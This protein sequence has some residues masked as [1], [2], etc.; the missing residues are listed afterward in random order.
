MNL[1]CKTACNNIL[2]LIFIFISQGLRAFQ[3]G[4]ISHTNIRLK[5]FTIHNGLPGETVRCIFQDKE[6]FIWM[7]I[8][9]NGLCRFNGVQFDIFG[10]TTGDSVSLSSDYIEVIEEDNYGNLWIGTDFG[11][12]KLNKSLI[13]ISQGKKFERFFNDENNP[14]SLSGNAVYDILKDSEGT[15][16]IGTNG[17][18][19][20]LN[21]AGNGFQNFCFKIK[22]FD[23]NKV[24]VNAIYEDKNKY[25]WI[26]T[27]NGLFLIS[28]ERKLVNHWDKSSS[29]LNNDY[30]NTVCEDKYGRIW[31]GTQSG[32]N[33]FEPSEN[34]FSHLKFT[35]S[36]AYMYFAGI[37]KIK[38]SS[39]EK[40][41]IGS[42][43][44]G[45]IIY[46]IEENTYNYLNSEDKNPDGILSNQ[47]RHFFED[48][49]GMMWIA[50][51]NK[52]IYTYD[53]R[54]ETFEYIN[55]AT[56]KNPGLSDKH[57][58]S[59]YEDSKGYIWIG[60]RFGGL[61]RYDPVT[62]KFTYYQENPK[63]P[64]GVYINRIECIIEDKEGLLWLSTVD[65]L[66]KYDPKANHFVHYEFVPTKVVLEDLNGNLWLGT[67]KGVYSFDKK[68]EVYVPLG[69]N[70]NSYP[71]NSTI[72][73]MLEDSY[74]KIWIGTH[75]SGLLEYDIITDSIYWYKSDNKPG[76]LNNNMVR[77]IYEDSQ[78][79]LWIGSKQ[80]GF[81][82]FERE[83]KTFR[84][85]NMKDGLPSNSV[86]S[87]TGD[88]SG[89]LWFATNKGISK[90]NIENK[91]FT[92]FSSEYGLQGD[93]FI[94]G[95]VCKTKDGKI[96]FG[97][98]NGINSFY[99][100]K[101]DKK[102]YSAPIAITAIKR[103]ENYISTANIEESSF[104]FRYND[105]LSF[106]FALLNFN[107]PQK[108]IYAYK[109][110]GLNDDWIMAGSRNYVSYINLPAG[111]YRFEVKG[112][113]IDG[114]W[115]DP[116]AVIPFKINPPWWISWHAVVFYFLSGIT[117]IYLAYEFVK[118]RA[119][120][121]HEVKVLKLE[122][123]QAENLSQFK[124][125]FFTNISHEIRT[126]LTLILPSVEK[127]CSV[128]EIPQEA[129]DHILNVKKN[130]NRLLNLVDEL[131]EFRKIE[132][133]Q[134]KLKCIK[135]DIID[136]IIE[137]T[138]LFKEAVFIKNIEFLIDTKYQ[139]FE[140]SF[141][142]GA[143]EKILS[144]LL[145]NAYKF[146][147]ED[148]KIEL[149]I[150]SVLINNPKSPKNFTAN[151]SEF[152]EI[153]VQDNGKGIPKE[154]L[155]NIFKR[156]YKVDSDDM[157][158]NNGIGIGL[159][160][161]KSLVQL[162]HGFIYA[163]ST[164]ETGS[165]FC[166]QIPVN[167][168]YY[169]KDEL[170]NY[171]LKAERYINGFNSALLSKISESKINL[172]NVGLN[173][174][175]D[176]SIL[177]VE[178][179]IE[180]LNLLLNIFSEKYH[181]Y[182]AVD[183]KTALKSANEK[184]PDLIISDV[185][186][187]ELNGT[188]FCMKIKSEFKTSHI[189]VILLSANAGID[190][191]IEGFESGADSYIAKPFH[192]KQLTTEVENLIKSRQKLKELFRKDIYSKPGEL[193]IPSLDEKFISKCLEI[194]DKYLAE[195]EFGVVELSREIGLSRT[196]LFRKLKALI[197]QT[198]L[199]FIYSIRLKRAAILLTEKKYPVSD[200]AYMTGFTNPG[201]FSTS[202]KRYF[203]ISPSE[204]IFE[205]TSVKK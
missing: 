9:S 14:Q 153:K 183:G 179:D 41:W 98:D 143:I 139:H 85:Y 168:Q 68:K 10:H 35:G 27:N 5:N 75:S 152:L 64:D 28:P 159:D 117:L 26:G 145:S 80:E 23:K 142:P 119:N 129:T 78:K 149:I 203:G 185:M 187:P 109:L 44:S 196:Q 169:T 46:N 101:I 114:Q 24:Q 52:G 122:K 161:T 39:D 94:S 87:I 61:N 34:T 12:N 6:G 193:N 74:G 92:N 190:Q 102:E 63:N 186:I 195:P 130:T 99:P 140:M 165:T 55:Q 76:C 104:I 2:V 21:N 60:T 115:S 33:V 83:S 100:E 42:F 113:R 70:K 54:I 175:K 86:F 133:G 110:N 131:L 166:V 8:E 150:S 180:I 30:I 40:L 77:A 29:T 57:V 173:I 134:M 167:E 22:N 56:E 182:T 19:S 172:K 184:L 146:T 51:K 53:K 156:F 162:H 137:I 18:L 43:T 97:G 66:L 89:N 95:A 16:W 189:P 47:I 123:D 136:F 197:G 128:N 178:D 105:H 170:L 163:E 118:Y 120:K 82:M 116:A 88:N 126:P 148:G 13:S 79:R 124:I 151:E 199:E 177:I 107:S 58:L 17:G 32:I 38:K 4:E 103:N 144:N 155:N 7:G 81:S 93:I 90:F 69:K 65:G 73:A 174:K 3:P 188:N 125:R 132:Q 194:T 111:K 59:I 147:G 176:F 205:N 171:P 15:I 202:F 48:R 181:V 72:T 91:I 37:N 191:K 45:L 135:A 67:K 121:E 127:L 157:S 141:D 96:Y 84:K 1:S 11:L 201:S 49:N 164:E 160:L 108:N 154:L 31:L 198:P 50:V 36:A 25:L 138:S 204:Y 106:E 20:K 62:K 192:I 112:A 158:N 200:V 71:V